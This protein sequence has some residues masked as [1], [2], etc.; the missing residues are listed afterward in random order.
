M[1]SG[2]ASP[3]NYFQTKSELSARSEGSLRGDRDVHR[4]L[5]RAQSHP[6]RAP[7]HSQR[8]KVRIDSGD[9]SW[10]IPSTA[11]FQ[12]SMF[13]VLGPRP[14]LLYGLAILTFRST[15]HPSDPCLA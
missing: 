1:A 11:W 3:R 15:G 6:S 10:S 13:G 2:V 12:D 7:L 5:A 4:Q 8:R 14:C 9:T